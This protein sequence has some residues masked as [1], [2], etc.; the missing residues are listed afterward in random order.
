[1]FDN[2]CSTLPFCGVLVLVVLF[3]APHALATT[4]QASHPTGQ[5]HHGPTAVQAPKTSRIQ[6]RTEQVT[7]TGANRASALTR[8]AGQTSF[9]SER[10]NFANHVAQ[11][12]ADM[13]A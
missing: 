9:S 2:S 6:A 13:I 3:P 8:P 12:V 4:E 7:V 5:K 1:M 11:S 10:D